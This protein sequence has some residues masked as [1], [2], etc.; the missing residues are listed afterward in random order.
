MG[1]VIHAAKQQAPLSIG[2]TF[3]PALKC[4]LLQLSSYCFAR[5]P[6]HLSN[7][8]KANRFGRTNMKAIGLQYLSWICPRILD[9]SYTEVR[10]YAV[11]ISQIQIHS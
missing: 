8:N 10:K 5:H 6:R 9:I 1:V 2:A 7:I 4:Q 11:D 3:H